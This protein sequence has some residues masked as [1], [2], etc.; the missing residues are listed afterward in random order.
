MIT[1]RWE[2]DG[3]PV[4]SSRAG[5]LRCASGSRHETV[6]PLF[7]FECS[8][9]E[10]R[11]SL[12]ADTCIVDGGYHFARGCL[13]IPVQGETEPFVSQSGVAEPEQLRDV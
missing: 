2:P 10:R 7:G 9:C 3:A 13:E 11:R 1:T 6:R 4:R 8:C 5:S 12:D